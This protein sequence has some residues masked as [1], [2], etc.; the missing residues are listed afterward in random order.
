MRKIEKDTVIRNI[1]Q[2][3]VLFMISKLLKNSII[4][5]SMIVFEFMVIRT[6]LG[7]RHYEN[8]YICFVMTTFLMTSIFLIVKINFGLAF[9]CTFFAAKVLSKEE[10]T[11]DTPRLLT[12]GFMY[13]PK[14]ETKYEVIDEYIKTY[15]ESKRLKEFEKRLESCGDEKTYEIY[16][17]RFRSRNKNNQIL[18]PSAIETILGMDRRRII[19]CL[20]HILLSFRVFCEIK[21]KK[22]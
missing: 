1:I 20:D 9:I 10:I 5:T 19:D 17:I 13:K 12:E 8:P 14:G 11:F 21:T 6:L 7:G 4:E 3:A 22:E 2:I 18:G 15:P 16:K